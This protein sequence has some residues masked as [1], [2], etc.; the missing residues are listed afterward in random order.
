M[1]VGDMTF[2]SIATGSPGYAS[3]PAT[4]HATSGTTSPG[5]ATAIGN[6]VYVFIGYNATLGGPFSV[7]SVK[8]SLGNVYSKAGGKQYLSG[9]GP[10]PSVEIWYFDGVAASSSLTVTVIFTGLCYFAIIVAAVTGCAPNGSVDVVSEGEAGSGTSSADP[11]S[12][13]SPNDLVFAFQCQV[14]GTGTLGTGGGFTHILYNQS[15]SSVGG[16]V[17][18]SGFDLIVSP[19]NAADSSL[20]WT[21]AYPFAIITVAIKSPLPWSGVPGRSAL[22][23]SP[24]GISNG[25]SAIINGGADYGVDTPGTITGG[26]NE[27]I[28]AAPAGARIVGLP[29]TFNITTTIVV[30]KSLAIELSEG[31]I[32]AIASGVTFP[33]SIGGPTGVMWTQALVVVNCSNVVIRG[34]QFENQNTGNNAISAIV[35]GGSTSDIVVQGVSVSGFTRWAY[36]VTAYIDLSSLNTNFPT[37]FDGPVSN[38]TFRDCVAN[39]C[40]Y[41]T[42]SNNTDGGGFKLTNQSTSSNVT[43]RVR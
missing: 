17:T 32:I 5:I 27:A 26:W 24:V 37:P 15:G 25:S 30:W 28:A 11:I 29:G 13:L 31:C 12:T 8:D 42:S 36:W 6:S 19:P 20:S 1:G 7:L 33:S 10:W 16:D 14:Q 41:Y 38:I 18:L 34:G 4:M 3:A 35:V 39:G 40:G 21:T 2:P 22:T 43:L 9:S 23:V